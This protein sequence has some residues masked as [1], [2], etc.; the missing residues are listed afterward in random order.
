M[1]SGRI[2]LLETRLCSHTEPHI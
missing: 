1:K 2:M